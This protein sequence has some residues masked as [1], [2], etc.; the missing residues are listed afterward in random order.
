M[1][2]RMKPFSVCNKYNHFN[3]VTSP[4]LFPLNHDCFLSRTIRLF[5]RQLLDFFTTEISHE[6][7]SEPVER[8]SLHDLLVFFFLL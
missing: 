7:Q 4:R 5:L 8:L 3:R 1:K 2:H 6:L